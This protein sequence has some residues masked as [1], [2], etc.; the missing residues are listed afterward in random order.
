[1][2]KFKSSENFFQ[3]QLHRI[4]LSTIFGIF[5]LATIILLI[6]IHIQFREFN[7]LIDGFFAFLLLIF[8]GGPLIQYFIS[9]TVIILDDNK[10][11]IPGNGY[12]GFFFP[13]IDK[14]EGYWWQIKQQVLVISSK[15]S[16]I[17]RVWQVKD[18]SEIKD[19]QI[20][21][22][23]YN[24]NAIIGVGGISVRAGDIG[25]LYRDLVN[26][27]PFGTESV[28]KACKYNYAFQP[29]GLIAI[30]F[31]ELPLIITDSTKDILG[32]DLSNNL[33]KF[34]PVLKKQVI[35]LSIKNPEKF[36]EE[37]SN[38]TNSI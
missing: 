18:E 24:L 26:K 13:G 2:I 3:Y 33:G 27:K 37:L 1:M 12:N 10:I 31:K 30:E 11:K 5:A 29:R 25:G 34:F 35:Y 4:I 19:T 23:I 9:R 32:N 16:N 6:F 20:N 38:R 15:Y 14:Y 8:I 36:V 21:R 7:L 22:S 17:S 28:Q